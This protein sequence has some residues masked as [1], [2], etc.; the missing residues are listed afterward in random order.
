MW[1]SG[2]GRQLACATRDGSVRIIDADTGAVLDRDAPEESLIETSGA[3]QLLDSRWRC[4]RVEPARNSSSSRLS[5]PRQIRAVS[6]RLRPVPL[7]LLPDD[8]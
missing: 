1:Q 2:L 4:R 5:G 6:G 8:H 3:A 7:A